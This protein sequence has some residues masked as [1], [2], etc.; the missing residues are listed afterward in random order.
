MG[1]YYHTDSGREGKFMFG[2][3][4][5][6]DPQYMGMTGQEPTS[7]DYYADKDDEPEIRRMLD[8]Q[9]D[10][11]GIPQDKRLYYTDK[12][13]E[14]YD[15]FEKEYLYP[16]VFVSVKEDDKEELEK[17][18]KDIKY[19]DDKQGYVMFEIKGMAIVLA[20]IRLG[21]T[22]LSDIKDNG[23]CWLNAEL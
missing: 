3:Q 19:A 14:E 11:I 12:K 10:I 7:I 6:D 1:R 20:R 4:S 22:I 9:Y 17:H 18:K 5:S 23:E 15:K 21:I 2:V 8:K 13:W 16:K